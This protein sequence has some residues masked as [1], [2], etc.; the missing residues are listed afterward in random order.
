VVF[1]E[2]HGTT[3]SAQYVLVAEPQ[4]TVFDSPCQSR[5]QGTA[6]CFSL[7]PCIEQD[8]VVFVSFAFAEPQGDDSGSSFNFVLADPRGTICLVS[9]CGTAGRRFY[10][11]VS[12]AL[13]EPQV[14]AFLVSFAL[15]APQGNVLTRGFRFAFAELQGTAV[16]VSFALAETQGHDFVCGTAGHHFLV[17]SV[18]AAEP[19]DKA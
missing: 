15:A 12:V 5:L 16:L 18:H 17:C 11:L 4:G 3:L 10:F 14:A 1:A 19:Q 6:I 7:G 2:P 9:P 13:V 8:T